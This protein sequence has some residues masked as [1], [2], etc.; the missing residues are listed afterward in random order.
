MA[1]GFFGIF[2]YGLRK[3]K[4]DHEELRGILS[5]Q[6][7]LCLNYFEMTGYFQLFLKDNIGVTWRK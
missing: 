4:M 3:L 1:F 6:F 7:R 5:F 2:F